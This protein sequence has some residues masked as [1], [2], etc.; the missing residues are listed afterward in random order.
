MQPARRPPEPPDGPCDARNVFSVRASRSGSGLLVPVS[1]GDRP[2]VWVHPIA[3]KFRLARPAGRPAWHAVCRF[4]AETR[5]DRNGDGA[6]RTG[7]R[8]GAPGRAASSGAACHDAGRPRRQPNRRRIHSAVRRREGRCSDSC[9]SP[10]EGNDEAAAQYL[11]TTL[12]GRPAEVLARQ[13][14][15][16]CSTPGCRR[17]STRSAIALRVAGHQ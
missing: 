14:R 9:D 2:A 7:H 12:Q 10:A 3:W 16:S 15:T 5:E 4:F 6:A 17:A 11:N 1:S 13:L 8:S